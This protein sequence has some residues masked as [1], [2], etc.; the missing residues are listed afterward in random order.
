M[1]E[2]IE[3]QKTGF[4]FGKHRLTVTGVIKNWVFH[5][6]TY[7]LLTVRTHDN[8]NYVSLRL[9]NQTG[10]FIK[11]LLVEPEIAQFI[12]QGF[13]TEWPDTLNKAVEVFGKE[14]QIDMAEEECAELIVSIKHLKRNRCG[15]EAVIEECVDVELMIE[16]MQNIFKDKLGL[17]G[18]IKAEK[19]ERLAKLVEAGGD[20]RLKEVNDG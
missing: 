8:L 17:W 5:G 10:R 20:I 13:Y 16:Q 3:K 4:K 14:K 9:Y 11:Q 6:R 18:N 7:R 2:G 1:V 15:E 12:F 19:M